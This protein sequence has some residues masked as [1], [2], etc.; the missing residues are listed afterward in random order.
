M[1]MSSRV[2][3]REDLKRGDDVYVLVKYGAHGEQVKRKKA[4]ITD[5]LRAAVVVDRIEGEQGARTVRFSDLELV[6]PGTPPPSVVQ[7]RKLLTSVDMEQPLREVPLALAALADTF[8]A[9][10][11]A[12]ARGQVCG[13]ALG[14][15]TQA[16][17]RAAV[18]ANRR[19]A[20]GAARAFGQ[21]GGVRTVQDGGL[22]WCTEAP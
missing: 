20:G 9:D 15:S 13:S 10:E 16:Q 2:I 6:V 18:L 21:R 14:V 4:R 8:A 3:R 5:V 12:G 1:A 11:T 22:M 7:K 17:R 19:R